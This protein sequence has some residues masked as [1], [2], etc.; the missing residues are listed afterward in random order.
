VVIG[1]ECTRCG[2]DQEEYGIDC[3]EEEEPARKEE[4][5]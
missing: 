3:D 5:P 2:A 1:K 4:R